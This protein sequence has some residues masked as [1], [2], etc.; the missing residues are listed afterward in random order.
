[1]KGLC[2]FTVGMAWVVGV[3]VGG[4]GVLGLSQADWAPYSPGSP[5][6]THQSPINRRRQRE[7]ERAFESQSV[8]F[9][10]L[11]REDVELQPAH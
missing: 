3:G 5:T 9:W 2:A 11:R 7:R 4:G 1:M 10:P 6:H 8:A